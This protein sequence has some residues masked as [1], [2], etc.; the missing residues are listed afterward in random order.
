M[1]ELKEGKRLLSAFYI[2]GKE[3][4]NL[5]FQDAIFT[6]DMLTAKKDWCVHLL[7]ANS[8]H[9]ASRNYLH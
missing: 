2:I 7:L 6:E 5:P 8:A 9:I 4:C 1:N 3:V